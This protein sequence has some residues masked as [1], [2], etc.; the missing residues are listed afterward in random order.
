MQS[1]NDKDG[2]AIDDDE[3]AIPLRGNGK[4]NSRSLG[5]QRFVVLRGWESCKDAKLPQYH[6]YCKR[7]DK[8]QTNIDFSRFNDENI[9]TNLNSIVNPFLKHLFSKNN[10]HSWPFRDALLDRPYHYLGNYHDQIA[11][12]K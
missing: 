5:F 2:N 12:D 1:E 10:G 9:I 8:K 4:C 11:I 7:N 3:V 6:S